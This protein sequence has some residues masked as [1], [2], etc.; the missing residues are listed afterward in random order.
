M[1]FSYYILLLLFLCTCSCR[2]DRLGEFCNKDTN[3]SGNT[4][5]SANIDALLAKLVSGTA[6]SG[7]IA[8]S[9]GKDQDKVYGL[10]QCRGDVSSKD[11]SNCIQDASKQI[12]QLCPDQADARIWFDYC[13]LR[14][15]DKNF[16]GNIDTSFAIFYFNVENVTDP[17]EFNKQ[18]G[19]LID[20]IRA[21]AVEPK[22]QGLGKGETKLSP[23]VTLYA[24]VQCTRDLPQID[25]AQCLAIAVGNFPNF[26]DNRKG[27]RALYSSCY[28]RYELYPFFFPIDSNKRMAE[29]SMVV[30]HQ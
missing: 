22:N 13:F 25:C 30:V 28:V 16:I 4:H 14:Y 1:A 29:T 5:I 18:L 3:I 15:N 11:C 24:L 6:S 10:S 2:A 17:E 7:Y 20:Q 9:Y 26:C 21:Q 8:T 23:L 27:C 19:A 12:R